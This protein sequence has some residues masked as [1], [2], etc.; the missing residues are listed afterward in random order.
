[1]FLERANVLARVIEN[2]IY[3]AGA[4]NIDHKQALQMASSA[5]LQTRERGGIVYVIGNG[6]S[7][8]IASHF[9]T[10]LMKTLEIPS[11]SLYDSN[12]TTCVSN[13]YGY[14]HVFSHPLKILLREED[15]LVAISS[16]GK[17]RNILNGVE[18]AQAKGARVMT[19]SG[20]LPGNPLRK[21]GNLN[22]Y[23]DSQEYGLVE[24]GHFFLLH[25]MIDYLQQHLSPN[26]K[27]AKGAVL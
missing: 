18:A 15:F 10:D 6:G 3:T 20:F 8:G 25:T 27:V 5:L 16:S 26:R 13:D 11:V 17:S 2:C 12:L 24:M 23:L 21:G 19:L 4:A 9:H 7:A 1:M 22:F 14:E